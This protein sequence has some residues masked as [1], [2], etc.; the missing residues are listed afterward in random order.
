M[1]ATKKINSSPHRNS[2]PLRWAINH[3]PNNKHITP[4]T[5]YSK[6]FSRTACFL[7]AYKLHAERQD[8]GRTAMPEICY[9]TVGFYPRGSRLHT[10]S[11]DK[12][13]RHF[14]RSL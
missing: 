5:L 8:P 1:V 6:R 14:H 10:A 2:R 4:F 3:P 7:L 11:P 9:P 12:M 13:P